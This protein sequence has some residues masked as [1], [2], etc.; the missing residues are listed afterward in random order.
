M[1]NFL[2]TATALA[3]VATTSVA[4]ATQP[5][6]NP[7]YIEHGKHDPGARVVS[8]L[9]LLPVA[10]VAGVAQI[11]RIFN[12]DELNASADKA[13]CPTKQMWRHIRNK[14]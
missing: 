10:I 3:F 7:K 14:E 8:T 13:L 11:P 5:C 1:K 6:V 2:I 9:L 12:D 4:I